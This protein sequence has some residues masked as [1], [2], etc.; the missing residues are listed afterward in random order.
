LRGA[1][2]IGDDGVETHASEQLMQVRPG[3]STDAADF[4]GKQKVEPV[5]TVCLAV[6]G[7]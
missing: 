7:P 6:S 5:A 4:I 2:E 3:A 1:V